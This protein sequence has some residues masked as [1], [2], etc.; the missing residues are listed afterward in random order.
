[1]GRVVHISYS[2]SFGGHQVNC[3]LLCVNMFATLDLKTP[4]GRAKILALRIP[5]VGDVTRALYSNIMIEI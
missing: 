2:K 3:A 5:K 1:M 4:G